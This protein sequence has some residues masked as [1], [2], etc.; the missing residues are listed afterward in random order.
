MKSYKINSRD[1]V[2]K[3]SKLKN[4]EALVYLLNH[5]LYLMSYVLLN[6]I[7]CFYNGSLHPKLDMVQQGS[8][9]GFYV[10]TL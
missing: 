2:C 7:L 1:L 6:P 10:L 8:Y 5:P 9:L 4:I 3:D